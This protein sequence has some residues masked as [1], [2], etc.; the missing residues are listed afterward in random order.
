MAV[1]KFVDRLITPHPPL[2]HLNLIQP[3]PLTAKKDFSPG[4]H[5]QIAIAQSIILYGRKHIVAA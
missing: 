3:F 5:F 1:K 4:G 2:L